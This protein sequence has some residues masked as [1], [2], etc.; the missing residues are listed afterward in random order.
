MRDTSLYF[1]S[2]ERGATAYRQL[3]F[4]YEHLRE[5]KSASENA[6]RFRRWRGKSIEENAEERRNF[7]STNGD[8]EISEYSVQQM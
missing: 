1:S 5:C 7:R 3:E 4:N 2:A 8:F 6:Q